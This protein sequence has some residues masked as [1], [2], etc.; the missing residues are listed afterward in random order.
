MTDV[1]TKRDDEKQTQI[2]REVSHVKMEAEI[3]VMLP[4]AKKH[5]GLPEAARGKEISSV[6]CLGRSLV[7][8][9]P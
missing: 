3:G 5:Q 7:L 6:R 9:A 8:P 4:Q 2:Q 1:L